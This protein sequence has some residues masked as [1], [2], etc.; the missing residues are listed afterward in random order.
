[1]LGYVGAAAAWLRYAEQHW[2]TVPE[3]PE[4][5]YFGTG[6]VAIQSLEAVAEHAFVCAVL[7]RRPG[8]DPA[9]AGL[10]REVLIGRALGGLRYL[11]ETHATGSMAC[12]PASA[13]RPETGAE[14]D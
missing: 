13:G 1:M 8:Y 7:A 4:L 14:T 12:V 11:A 5:G 2:H 10:D 9:A 6:T 3:R